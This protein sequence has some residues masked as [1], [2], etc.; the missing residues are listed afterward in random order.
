MDVCRDLYR[1]YQQ[2]ADGISG[3]M[4][5]TYDSVRGVGYYKG[6]STRDRAHQLFLEAQKVRSEATRAKARCA[7]KVRALRRHA[8]ADAAGS[9][10]SNAALKAVGLGG[11]EGALAGLSESDNWR[12]SQRAKTGLTTLRVAKFLHLGEGERKLLGDAGAYGFK[13]GQE[14]LLNTRGADMLQ[15]LIIEETLEGIIDIHA[16][17]LDDLQAAFDRLEDEQFAIEAEQR[18]G[19]SAQ[20]HARSIDAAVRVSRRAV[21]GGSDTAASEESGYVAAANASKTAAKK[22]IAARGEQ[23]AAAARTAARAANSRSTS[24]TTTP[25]KNRAKPSAR[26][27]QKTAS[28]RTAPASTRRSGGYAW[29]DAVHCVRK[30]GLKFYGS[31]SCRLYLLFVSNSRKGWYVPAEQSAGGNNTYHADLSD[32]RL[33]SPYYFFACHNADTQCVSTAKCV[34]RKSWRSGYTPHDYYPSAN[35]LL[36]S[37]GLSTNNFRKLG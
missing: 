30:R 4:K 1:R 11:L 37:C 3:Q 7:E 23:A 28:R 19:A 25:K 35:A 32:A 16:A 15:K 24:K 10:L 2:I 27:N 31:S 13:A 21:Q 20:A 5:D 6:K 36:K 12:I 29:G 34:R 14:L 26:S 22:L 18:I 9:G 33:S 8:A 17:A